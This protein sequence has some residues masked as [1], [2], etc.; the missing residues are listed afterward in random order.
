MRVKWQ[1]IHATGED[2]WP[3]GVADVNDACI[4]GVL[5]SAQRTY[6]QVVAR[7]RYGSLITSQVVA[8]EQGVRGIIQLNGC[9]CRAASMRLDTLPWSTALQLTDDS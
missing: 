2:L 7:C 6:S 9:V 4:D 5:P 1:V 8:S 3:Q